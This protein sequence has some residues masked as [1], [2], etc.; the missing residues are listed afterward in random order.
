MDTEVSARTGGAKRIRRAAFVYLA[1][2]SGTYYLGNDVGYSV[3][4]RPQLGLQYL[5]AVLER[6]GIHTNIL[7]QTVTW[8][9]EKGLIGM[10]KDYDIA[11][12]YCSDPHEDKVKAYCIA[13]KESLSIPILVGGPATLANSTFLDHGCDI[14]VHGEGERTVEEIVEYYNGRRELDRI[15]GISYKSGG[16]IVKTRPRE[17]IQNLND[18]PFPDR[19]KVDIRA[20]HDLFLFGMKKP[21]VTMIAS[22][23][24]AYK[25]YFCT[26]YKIWGNRYRIRSVDSVMA[27]I[28]DVVER[29]K[30]RYIA[31]QDDILGL[32]N[33]WIEDLCEK[34]IKK[35]YKIRWMAI[36]HP[37]SIPRDKERV[38]KLMKRAGC[39]TLSFGLQSA[40]PVIL[41][42]I[43][44]NPAEPERL[45]E[46]L[47]IANKLNFVT[48][49]GYILGLPG[50]TRQTIKA[51]I[52]YSVACGSTVAS[53]YVLSVLKGSEIERL[54]GDK[55]ICELPRSEIEKFAEEAGRK[56]YMRQSAI[57]RIAYFIMINPGWILRVGRKLPSILARLGFIKGKVQKV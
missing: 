47:K 21:Y 7:D 6:K 14:V 34:L 57:L 44:R 52:D 11:G 36:L 32:T 30:A 4:R 15:D 39:D 56:F 13:I 22:R 35:P 37:F 48:S 25:C 51:T 17:L 49:I 16:N 23:G 45:S 28:D 5:C 54:Y 18:L 33:E 29:Y 2:E 20:Y 31:F 3:Q 12:F 50:D 46:I 53:Y 8:F 42:N 9:D 19:S 24:C 26:S 38:L 55:D 10:L 1:Q 43:N 41:K 27:E 40:H